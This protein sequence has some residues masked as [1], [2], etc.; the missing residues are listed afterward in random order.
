M[1]AGAALLCVLL[2]AAASPAPADDVAFVELRH[3]RE[4]CF[5][6]EEVPL[7]LRFGFEQ[8]FL[9][10]GLV[11]L[12]RRQLDVPAQL[13]ASWLDG[14]PGARVTLV[15][16]APGAARTVAAND[17]VAA[18]ER[19]PDEDRGGRAFAVFALDLRLSA[20]SPG[21]LELDA[22]VLR[23][24][25][26]SA[27]A[28]DLA[29]GRVAADPT[30]VEVAGSPLHLAVQ[31]LP[32]EGR[33]PSFSGAVGRFTAAAEASP[34]SLA[35]GQGLKLVLT[36]AGTGNLAG[37]EAPALELP[38]FHVRGYVEEQV[39]GRRAITYDLAPPAEGVA[40]IP[41]IDFAFFDPEPPGAY[42]VARTEPLALERL[43]APGAAAPDTQAERRQ[44]NAWIALAAFVLALGAALAALALRARRAKTA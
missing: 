23:F 43:P 1:S 28:D 11:P 15:P 26:A 34:R 14:L 32:E 22:P 17:A 41:P 7:S 31:A 16:P 12:F 13:A 44:G 38:G 30:P 39:P 9:A 24:A 18:V 5:A 10:D 21:A 4:T 36:L 40:L 3:A 20:A 37:F 19:L 2:Q 27:F 8:A 25:R 6:G 42:R 29:Q 35:P 33:P